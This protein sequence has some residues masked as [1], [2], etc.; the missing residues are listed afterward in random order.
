MTGLN[1]GY[2]NKSGSVF[3]L[4]K[5]NNTGMKKYLVLNLNPVT[6]TFPVR[7]INQVS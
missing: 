3:N 1:T 4:G 6:Y 5:R 2:G 7:E